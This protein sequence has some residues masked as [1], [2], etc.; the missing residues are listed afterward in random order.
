MKSI[1]KELAAAWKAEKRRWVKDA[2]YA[3]Y[4]QH[5]NNHVLPFLEGLPEGT[6]PASTLQSFVDAKSAQGLSPKSIR[7]IALVLKMFLR[8]GAGKGAWT[9]PVMDVRYPERSAVRAPEV[10]TI[11][12]QRR[13]AGYLRENFSFR[14]LG[15]LIAM[16]TG[17]R[18]GEIAGLRW[19]D[20]DIPTGTIRVRRTAQRIYIADGPAR[21]Y[22][23]TVGSPKT[24]L[25][26]R[27]IPISSA[28]MGML[29]PLRRVMRPE[30]Y[31]ISNGP[32]PIEPRTLREW[33][34]RLLDSLGIA[35]VRFHALR[36]TFA[37][38]C[39]ECGCDTKTVSAILGHASVST[40]L[41]LY[42]H[43]GI[44]QKK[45]AIERMGR[46]VW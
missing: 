38:R 11:A 27:D 10:L 41:D 34:A 1:Y 31:V 45:R 29:R 39:I 35:R 30:S 9:M 43:P 6:I 23:L 3:V 32:R 2:T 19:E 5:L 42:V 25:S 22:E 21:Q 24:L 37:T 46:K 15:V 44:E 4:V 28:L 8:Y 12:D 20:I 33:F 36:H 16:N 13:L 18:I 7:D 40:T 14:G 26:V 17:M